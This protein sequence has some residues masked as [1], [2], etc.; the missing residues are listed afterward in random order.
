MQNKTSS[1]EELQ[2]KAR[3]W[4]NHLRDRC[5][6]QVQVGLFPIQEMCVCVFILITV[7]FNNIWFV[8]AFCWPQLAD[9]T[10]NHKNMQRIQTCWL[11]SMEY[12]CKHIIYYIVYKKS[13]YVK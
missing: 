13:K 12:Y 10:V 7:G 5:I 1:Q 9:V 8:F 6:D 11:S 4:R 2:V 3:F